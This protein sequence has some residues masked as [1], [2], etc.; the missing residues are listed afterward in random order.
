MDEASPAISGRSSPA[1]AWGWVIQK[2]DWPR[3]WLL[4]SIINP[5]KPAIQ[6]TETKDEI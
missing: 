4:P 5:R 6:Q 1:M 3:V 2:A